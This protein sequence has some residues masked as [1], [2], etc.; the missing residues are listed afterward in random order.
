MVCLLHKTGYLAKSL[1]IEY[2]LNSRTFCSNLSDKMWREQKYQFGH[3][4]GFFTAISHYLFFKNPEN[5][6]RTSCLQKFQ[7]MM[8]WG[9]YLRR[10]YSLSLQ[11]DEHLD[12]LYEDEVHEVLWW[13]DL[14]KLSEVLQKG[15]LLWCG[16]QQSP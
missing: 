13:A 14:Y 8:E 7:T 3:L 16:D 10:C 4:L 2:C 11:C 15:S 1:M 6:L 12:H 5:P 9:G